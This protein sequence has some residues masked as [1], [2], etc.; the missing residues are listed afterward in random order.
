MINGYEIREN[1]VTSNSVFLFLL[2]ADEE[3]RKKIEENL[4]AFCK[5][6]NLK[7]K[8]FDYVF[9]LAGIRDDSMLD[10]F[11]N[12]VE[13]LSSPVNPVTHTFGNPL[14]T[15]TITLNNTS[16]MPKIEST[17]V[18]E[19][20]EENNASDVLAEPKKYPSMPSL[21]LGESKS[22]ET[23]KLAESGF[24]ISQEKPTMELNDLSFNE[25]FSSEDING[26]AVEGNSLKIEKTIPE[27][28]PSNQEDN[29][30]QGQK[31]VPQE[32]DNVSD[33][34]EAN[35]TIV[36]F[37][38]EEMKG[39]A[40]SIE[41]PREKKNIFG[42]LFKKV[43]NI[44]NSK[45]E[46]EVV[47]QAEK[48]IK[49]E[50]AKEVNK[51][52]Q[53]VQQE[54]KKE[55][56]EKAIEN[57]I[58]SEQPTKKF[59]LFKKAKE[60]KGKVENS[61]VVK[62]AQEKAQEI[63]N[64]V[65]QEFQEEEKKPEPVK[66][67]NPF[68]DLGNGIIVKKGLFSSES[69]EEAIQKEKEDLTTNPITA[70]IKVD[71]IFAAETVYDFYADQPK[72]ES[73]NENFE[74]NHQKEE[75]VHAAPVQAEVKPEPQSVVQKQEEKQEVQ[76]TENKKEEILETEIGDRKTPAIAPVPVTETIKNI[77]GTEQNIPAEEK[78]KKPEGIKQPIKVQ[79]QK[80]IIKKQ[81]EE[82]TTHKIAETKQI[83]P[84][85]GVSK[86]ENIRDIFE[87]ETQKDKYSQ[88]NTEVFKSVFK[89][90]GEAETI[91]FFETRKDNAEEKETTV[92]T[93][94][95]ESETA[96][97]AGETPA[98]FQMQQV[99]AS[100]PVE[101]KT[102]QVVEQ[103][104]VQKIQK[105][106]KK[107]D[108]KAQESKQITKEEPS[109]QPVQEQSLPK[110]EQQ[111]EQQPEENISNGVEESKESAVK[112]DLKKE[113]T[114]MQEQNKEKNMQLHIEQG[115]AGKDFPSKN[116]VAAHKE[117]I[118]HTLHVG[119]PAKGSKYKNYPI[120]M[121]LIPTYT[122]ANM[123]ISPI[124]FAHAMAM[125]T[126][127][128]LGTAN[129]PF[130]LQGVSGTGKT[131]FLHAMGYEISKKVPQSKILFTN[132]VRFSRGIQYALEKGQKEKLDAFFKG[133]EALIVDD[134][135]L[136]AVNE[137]NREYISKVLNYF[138]KHK[139]QIIFSSKYPPESLQRFEELVNFKFALGTITELK[140]P[141]KVHF[142]RLTEKMVS[143]ANLE[144]SEIQVQEFFCNRCNSLGDVARDI[145]RV[146]VLSRRIESSGI[147]MPSS[148]H[149]LSV[150]TGTNGENEESEIVKK[151]FEDITVLTKN[152]DDKWGNF[153]FFFPA[154]Q[155]DKFR[156]VAF[157]SQE[158]AKEL[159]IKGGFNYSLKS[160]YSTEHI[161]SAAFKI[162]NICDIKGLKGAVILGPSLM[163]VKEPI[164]D[165]FYDILSHM[166]EVMMIRCGTIN[167]ENI[168]KPSA[169]VKMLGDIL[170]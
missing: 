139:K 78:N 6:T 40:I 165:N 35:K 30:A 159:G 135:H 17:H 138:F 131:H 127:E 84:K 91:S 4:S 29:S 150:M 41:R 100:K 42:G 25:D 104:P 163:E 59:S 153:G 158:A 55:V 53:K 168:K 110:E 132:G 136:T 34:E 73:K 63:K 69:V 112:Q 72:Q 156:W 101:K 102:E 93:T 52:A 157:A 85:K 111:Q 71:D 20:K 96:S 87:S 88:L 124:R 95:T 169:Y 160:A 167:F 118:D 36:S 154:N 120:E 11:K 19:D 122:F 1:T 74:Q 57:N 67:E 86:Q 9:E 39:V 14:K 77:F 16:T 50:V 3:G 148:E 108:L 22:S 133:M 94:K 143:G 10:K 151:N 141:N 56:K 92:S 70:R 89:E 26:I 64:E 46:E 31:D 38:P 21:D 164:R 113:K 82:E 79:E 162:A 97:L 126:L 83:T 43:K 48:E 13:N 28:P 61:D 44:F 98:K 37:T 103:G 123:D 66:N 146:K 90:R 76:V 147:K 23:L 47:P 62:H 105:E 51:K 109:K 7:V 45:K 140:I 54:I 130:L 81:E 24:P 142:E 152:N 49:K 80:P 155:I 2:K 75:V 134:V 170:K 68:Q 32:E 5:L 58:I 106:E 65:K 12:Q 115:S 8:G 128:N 129:N 137:H 15:E 145:K 18:K 161:I 144:L 149:I 60:I 107:E 121:P 166:L 119:T 116:E 27:L 117:K 99:S 125:S 114:S 33:L